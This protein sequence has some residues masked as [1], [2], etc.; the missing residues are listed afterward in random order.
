M[1]IY[2][3][4]RAER[5]NVVDL[6]WETLMK[7]CSEKTT[8]DR[9]MVRGLQS[10]VDRYQ[11]EFLSKHPNSTGYYYPRYEIHGRIEHGSPHI[12]YLARPYLNYSVSRPGSF[13]QYGKLC[14]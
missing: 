7:K 14:V 8:M 5:T 1:C 3:S 12:S 10:E 11:R 6:E 9:V 4:A 2:P 13:K